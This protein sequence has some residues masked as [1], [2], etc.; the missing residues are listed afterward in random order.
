LLADRTIHRWLV[1]HKDV[2]A[3]L[4]VATLVAPAS[5]IIAT[6]S[7]DLMDMRCH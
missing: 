3:Q 4:L 2:P 1:R 5:F 6:S 7:S